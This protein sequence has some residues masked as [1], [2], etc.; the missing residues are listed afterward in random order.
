MTDRKT[1]IAKSIFLSISTFHQELFL[2]SS[3]YWRSR[4][5]DQVGLPLSVE[6]SFSVNPKFMGESIQYNTIKS[7]QPWEGK[8]ISE[9]VVPFSLFHM[10][11][12]TWC[13]LLNMTM[14]NK[15]M[16]KHSLYW[17]RHIPPG[18]EHLFAH[19]HLIT[20]WTREIDA[21]KCN[22]YEWSA[23]KW[24]S[25]CK[26]WSIKEVLCTSPRHFGICKWFVGFGRSSGYISSLA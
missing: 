9:R 2:F 16:F 3:I 26:K 17:C 10:I 23:I 6:G 5:L 24:E 13:W 25:P 19:Y 11:A 4:I 20:I 18:G 15:A 12:L 8:G 22:N 7:C 14:A 21:I 1:L